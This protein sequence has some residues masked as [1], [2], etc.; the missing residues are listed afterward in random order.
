MQC[1]S[2]SLDVP[3][4]SEISSRA[5]SVISKK[6]SAQSQTTFTAR[7]SKNTTTSTENRFAQ[8]AA[9][10]NFPIPDLASIQNE[11]FKAQEPSNFDQI[12][13][14]VL[15]LQ[16]H[17]LTLLLRSEKSA[18]VLSNVDIDVIYNIT[19]AS[20]HPLSWW[21]RLQ[22]LPEVSD[23]KLV[24]RAENSLIMFGNNL[25]K[26]L[27]SSKDSGKHHLPRRKIRY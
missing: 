23:L 15:I 6:P 12:A 8:S 13:L 19:Q 5:S 20:G 10:L 14:L 22:K 18:I 3:T 1:I 17:L 25:F 2:G 24:K 16:N 9:L 4:P 21:K 7:S 11:P 26:A 27:A